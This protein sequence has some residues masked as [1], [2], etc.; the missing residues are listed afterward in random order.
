MQRPHSEP[1]LQEE[2]YEAELMFERFVFQLNQS[3]QLR[4]FYLETI[5]ERFSN[6]VKSKL[7]HLFVQAEALIEILEYEANLPQPV[8]DYA[9]Q[10][11]P[12]QQSDEQEILQLLE[13]SALTY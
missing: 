5:E 6:R 10:W 3:L 12:Q 9:D 8:H 11:E 2:L 4:K 1:A 7:T 13:Q